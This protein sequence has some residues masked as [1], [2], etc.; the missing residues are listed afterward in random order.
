MASKSMESRWE[1]GFP[2]D[3][4]VDQ[5]ASFAAALPGSINPLASDPAWLWVLRHV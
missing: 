1:N 2:H 5:I 4:K 3:P